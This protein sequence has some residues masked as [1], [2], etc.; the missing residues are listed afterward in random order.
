MG[1][2]ELSQ[3]N[4]ALVII[5][6][7]HGDVLLSSPVYAELKQH[8]PN[9]I[10]DALVYQDTSPMLTLNPNIHAVITIDRAWKKL[11]KLQQLKHEW[12]LLKKLRSNHYD[13][14]IHLTTHWR[15]AIISRLIQPGI[16]IAPDFLKKKRQGRLWRG[17]FNEFYPYQAGPHKHTVDKY[18]DALRFLGIKIPHQHSRLFIVP[19]EKAQNEAGQILFEANFIKGKY[20]L[21]HPTSRWLFKCWTER[22]MAQLIDALMQQGHQLVIT[23]AP[24][25]KEI[26]M[27]ERIIANLPCQPLNLAGKLNLKTL[28]ALIQ[29]A[30]LFIGVDS[31]PMHMAVALQTPCVALFGPSEM[32]EWGPWLSPHRV[33]NSRDYPRSQH[34]EIANTGKYKNNLSNVPFEAVWDAVQKMIVV[35]PPGK[36]DN[37]V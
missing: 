13:L 6:R 15:G 30:K 28:A 25:K 32:D 8:Y 19:G 18:L 27:V 7:H 29:K 35:D 12:L 36:N 20:L 37:P 33:V 21:I 31:V 3:P 11:P 1:Q 14:L 10:I 9:L 2:L 17:S 16:S 4:R 5:L 23:A 26:Q 22:R 24:D 34:D